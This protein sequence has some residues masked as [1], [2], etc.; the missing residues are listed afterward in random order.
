MRQ[1]VR[2]SFKAYSAQKVLEATAV[3]VNLDSRYKPR[4][5]PKPVIDAMQTGQA[6]ENSMQ[7]FE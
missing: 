6:L 7:Y 2:K 4:R 5:I 1:Q 3:V